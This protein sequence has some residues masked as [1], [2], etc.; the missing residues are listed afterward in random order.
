MRIVG[1]FQHDIRHALSRNKTQ[2]TGSHWNNVMHRE[3]K[4]NTQHNYYHYPQQNLHD[5]CIQSSPILHNPEYLHAK[6]Q[7][8]QQQHQQIR[9]A[10]DHGARSLSESAGIETEAGH[11]QAPT[12][13]WLTRSHGRLE[14][15]A[16]AV[17]GRDGAGAHYLI[18]TRT[19]W[20]KHK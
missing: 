19:H 6:H 14:T 10:L 8:H 7:V 15:G 13:A 2:K 1:N 12:P 5:Q 20:A 4:S 16:A 11:R 17:A 3:P 18:R 9:H